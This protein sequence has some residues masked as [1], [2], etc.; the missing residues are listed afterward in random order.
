MAVP[1]WVRIS[2]WVLAI[3]IGVSMLFG[4]GV[5]IMIYRQTT[6]ASSERADADREFERVRAL[7]P[8]R[9]PLVEVVKAE[10]SI[11]GV[12]INRV[13]ETSPRQSVEQFQVLVYDS[14]KKQLVR[15]HV[16][17]WLLRFSSGNIAAHLGLPVQNFTITLED[18]E[19]YGRGIIVDFSPPAGGRILIWT[20]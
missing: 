2:L 5:A 19:R 8:S 14:K 7:F 11:P 17:V 20:E 18:V 6:F 16:P 1:R 10:G 9:T 4:G 3:C 15:S 12:R 13:P